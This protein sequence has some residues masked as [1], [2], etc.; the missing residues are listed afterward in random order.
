MHSDRPQ[1]VRKAEQ[2]IRERED[3][4]TRRTKVA[5]RAFKKATNSQRSRSV[6]RMPPEQHVTWRTGSLALRRFSFSYLALQ[7]CTLC[8]AQAHQGKRLVIESCVGELG[9]GLCRGIEVRLHNGF[10]SAN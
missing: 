8:L 3:Y 6:T 4:E 1:I 9:R 5:V 7:T 10:V 2:R